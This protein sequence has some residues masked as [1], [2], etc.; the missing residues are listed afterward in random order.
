MSGPADAVVQISRLKKSLTPVATDWDGDGVWSP[1]LFSPATKT[2]YW[3]NALVSG[4]VTGVL[5]LRGVPSGVPVTGL[6]TSTSIGNHDPQ[7][8]TTSFPIS[9]SYNT[10]FDIVNGQ[11]V[12]KCY[13]NLQFSFPFEASDPD[14]D[15]LTWHWSVDS[16]TISW[17]GSSVTWTPVMLDC[18][19][20]QTAS[21]SFTITDGRGG[22][23]KGYI[24]ASFDW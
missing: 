9:R 6:S 14:G 3:V 18:F 23:A 20:Y 4:P 17:D 22:M 5:K 7:V 1:G 15:Q 19:S 2:F 11:L 12:P 21:I 16:G 8:L 13:T 10:S 24:D